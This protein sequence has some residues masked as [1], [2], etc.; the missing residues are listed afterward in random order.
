M[1]LD[2]NEIRKEYYFGYNNDRYQICVYDSPTKS[3]TQHD[4]DNMPDLIKWVNVNYIAWSR[5]VIDE[6]MPDDSSLD[7]LLFKIDTI[8]V[9]S[10]R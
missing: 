8:N 3:T 6:S 4:F 2:L 5:Y 7:E 9:K 1:D 10:L